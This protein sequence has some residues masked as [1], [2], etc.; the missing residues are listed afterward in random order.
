M[1]LALYDTDR[2]LI[3]IFCIVFLCVSFYKRFS[4]VY[5]K[6][7]RETVSADCNDSDFNFWHVVHNLILLF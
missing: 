6:A 1:D 5:G 7:F 2:T 4:S 3:D